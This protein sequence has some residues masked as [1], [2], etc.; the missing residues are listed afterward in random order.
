MKITKYK[1]VWE[2]WAQSKDRLFAYVLSRF[3]DRTLAEEVTQEVLLK[4]YQSCC[5]NREINNLNGWLYQIAHH[6]SLDIVKREKKHS[7]LNQADEGE[8]RSIVWEE[9]SFFL[10]PL[11]NFLPEKYATPLKMA[12][13]KGIPQKD[14]ATK[15]GLGLSA[16]KSRIQR[17]RMQLKQQILTCF[18]LETDK[19]GTP[20]NFELKDTCNPLKESMKNSE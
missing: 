1:Q 11:I 7:Q 9:L 2:I 5:S 14:I 8:N 16:T 20:I 10:E 4:M 3:K 19:N 12:D 18:N 6:A 13:L 17:A 15:L